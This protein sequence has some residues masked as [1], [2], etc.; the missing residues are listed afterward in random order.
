MF[1]IVFCGNDYIGMIIDTELIFC[2]M[3]AS[4][5]HTVV[6]VGGKFHARREID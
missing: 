6:L 3:I 5:A 1:A 4:K 2:F